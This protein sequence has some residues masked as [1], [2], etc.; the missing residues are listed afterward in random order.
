MR[1]HHEVLWDGTEDR[2][3]RRMIFARQS[4]QVPKPMV[5]LE[6]EP[7]VEPRRDV[8]YRLRRS[9]ALRGVWFTSLEASLAAGVSLMQ[10]RSC[11]AHSVVD[12]VMEAD[13]TQHRHRYRWK[14]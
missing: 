4:S 13:K 5:E 10:A 8:S 11:L 12:G 7:T 2:P 9:K 14:A 6:P 1:S 3:W